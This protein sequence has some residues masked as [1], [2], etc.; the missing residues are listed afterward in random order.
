MA[1]GHFLGR[2]RQFKLNHQHARLAQWAWSAPPPG[3]AGDG[4]G[5][6]GLLGRAPHGM[7][8]ERRELTA[9]ETHSVPGRSLV[10]AFT[11]CYEVRKAAIYLRAGGG[12]VDGQEHIVS[13]TCTAA[14]SPTS[15]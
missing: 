4:R 5:A 10:N 6:P 7:F 2:W 1:W 15:A 9:R 14:S 11:A 8:M 3:C 12:R 13:R